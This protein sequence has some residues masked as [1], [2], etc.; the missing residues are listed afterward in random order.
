[1]LFPRRELNPNHTDVLSAALTTRLQGQLTVRVNCSIWFSERM[2]G[3]L[4]IYTLHIHIYLYISFYFFHK[5]FPYKFSI[6]RMMYIAMHNLTM[7]TN[8]GNDQW[9]LITFEEEKEM[10]KLMCNPTL[11]MLLFP[12]LTKKSCWMETLQ[13]GFVMNSLKTNRTNR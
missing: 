4:H 7:P 11:G 8:A 2:S 1:M 6:D 3:I 9:S 10:A 12:D 5:N 13:P